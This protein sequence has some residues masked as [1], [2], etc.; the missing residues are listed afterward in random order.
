MSPK[1]LVKRKGGRMDDNRVP[2]EVKG[3]S[4]ILNKDLFLYLLD[5]EVK[6][7]RRY[8]NFL[9]LLMLNL[10]Q[11]SKDDGKYFLVCQQA[12]GRLLSAELR[13]TDLLGSLGKNSLVVLLP[14]ADPSAGGI[15][16]SRFEDIL[17][18]YDFRNKGFEVLVDQRCFP[19]NGTDAIDLIGEALKREPLESIG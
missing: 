3:L 1:G 4:R 9:S 11:L 16:K 14:Y 18:Y 10:K 6:R 8:Q 12:L 15:A 13:E 7:A 19:L 17:K 2:G 5:L